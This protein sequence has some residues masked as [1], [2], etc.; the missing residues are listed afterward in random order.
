[1]V[2]FRSCA[3]HGASILQK[4]KTWQLPACI[5]RV[6]AAKACLRQLV[7]ASFRGSLP[8]SSPLGCT[9]RL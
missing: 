7:N 8:A 4:S 9:F 3:D 2:Q 1:M 6:P 5:F